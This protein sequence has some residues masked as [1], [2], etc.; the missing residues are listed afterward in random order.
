[1]GKELQKSTHVSFEQLFKCKKS[2]FHKYIRQLAEENLKRVKGNAFQ[3]FLS[4]SYVLLYFISSIT[5][6][7]PTCANEPFVKFQKIGLISIG[8]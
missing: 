4:I 6:H 1:M 2:Y 3:Y 7:N 5:L 8:H